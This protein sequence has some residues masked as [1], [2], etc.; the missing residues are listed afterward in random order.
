MGNGDPA[1]TG[2]PLLLLLLLLRPLTPLACCCWL[3]HAATLTAMLTAAGQSPPLCCSFLQIELCSESNLFFHYVHELD[4]ASFRTLQVRTQG[5]WHMTVSW[6]MRR[7]LDTASL[8]NTAGEVWGRAH[9]CSMGHE[10]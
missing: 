8:Q 10:K 7:D 9:D 4:A 3:R 1:L 6:G 2:T 5:A